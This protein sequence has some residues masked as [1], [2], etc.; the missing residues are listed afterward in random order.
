MGLP[1][2]STSSSWKSRSS[3]TNCGKNCESAPSSSAPSAWTRIFLMS[4]TTRLSWSSAPL[5][6]AFSEL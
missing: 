1:S 4:C 6:I 5:L 2:S 3:H